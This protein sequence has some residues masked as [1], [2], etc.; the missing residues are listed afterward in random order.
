M[1]IYNCSVCS[2]TF[3]RKDLSCIK[4]VCS[5][6]FFRKDLACI[7]QICTEEIHRDNEKTNYKGNIIDDLKTQYNCKS[8]QKTLLNDEI[9][10]FASPQNIRQ[11]QNIKILKELNSL[12]E[13]L[14][15]LRLPF[16]Q[17]R[18]L[19]KKHRG[20]Q[21][22]LTG[23]VINVPIDTSRSQCALPHDIKETDTVAVAI[24]KGYATK[25]LMLSVAFAYTWS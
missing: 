9:P 12:E 14:L 4:Q 19:G 17:I 18:E 20:Q 7:K 25:M 5:R 2:S 3:F 11:N 15:S 23:G 13:R 10:K 6:T 8:C 22:G 21:L 1:P 24:K 16:L